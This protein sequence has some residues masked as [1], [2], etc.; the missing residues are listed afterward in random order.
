MEYFHVG[1]FVILGVCLI[2]KYGSQTTAFFS[3]F[4]CSSG[5]RDVMMKV[6]VKVVN[7][8]EYSHSH[9]ACLGVPFHFRP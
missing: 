1:I 3:I 4:Q 9:V 6:H 2:R 8:V 7:I 5:C